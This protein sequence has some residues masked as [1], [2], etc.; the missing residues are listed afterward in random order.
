MRKKPLE[1]M[2]SDYT[3]SENAIAIK[4]EVSLSSALGALHFFILLSADT[5]DSIPTFGRCEALP[6]GRKVRLAQKNMPPAIGTELSRTKE[7]AE[8]SRC[9]VRVLKT[10]SPAAKSGS[11]FP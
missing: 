4:A 3:N 9:V 7:D 2:L 11:R 1:R 6:G 8:R 10:I 5:E